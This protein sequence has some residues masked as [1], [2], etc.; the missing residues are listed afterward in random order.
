MLSVL[1]LG[2]LAAVVIAFL[3]STVDLMRRQSRP[4]DEVM[5]QRPTGGA[6]FRP[7]DETPAE[8]EPGLTIYRFGAPLYFANAHRFTE[9][10]TTLIDGPSDAPVRWFILYADA[11]SDLD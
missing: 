7:I 3:M 1:V 9:E 4:R 5:V 8:T 2:S 11:M 6:Q 10:V